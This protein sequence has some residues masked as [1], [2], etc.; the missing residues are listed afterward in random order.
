MSNK[1]DTVLSVKLDATGFKTGAKEVVSATED[2]SKAE[3]KQADA[4][5]K[6][7]DRILKEIRARIAKETRLRDAALRKI[8]ASEKR[9]EAGRNKARLAE[10]RQKTAQIKRETAEIKRNAT[11]K[12]AMQRHEDR[13]ARMQAKGNTVLEKRITLLSRLKRVALTIASLGAVKYMAGAVIGGT[14]AELKG[15]NRQIIMYRNLS[16]GIEEATKATEGYMSK[17]ALLDAASLAQTFQLDMN[18]KSFAV[19][20]RA[21]LKLSK[22]L[23]TDASMAVRDLTVGLARGSRQVLDNLAIIVN[24]EEAYQKYA[25]ANGLVANKLSEVEKRQAKFNEAIEQLKSKSDEGVL[26]LDNIGNAAEKASVQYENLTKSIWKY[27]AAQTATPGGGIGGVMKS[28]ASFMEEKTRLEMY[29]QE[30][31]REGKKGTALGK[32]SAWS[33]GPLAGLAGF[34]AT[35]EV[36]SV[37]EAGQ[38]AR[39][40]VSAEKLLGDSDIISG[41][42]GPIVN[43]LEDTHEDKLKKLEYVSNAIAADTTHY[44][45]WIAELAKGSMTVTEATNFVLKSI[46]TGEMPVKKLPGKYSS[47]GIDEITR[48]SRSGRGRRKVRGIDFGPQYSTLDRD[49]AEFQFKAEQELQKKRIENA[50]Y[51]DKI[52]KDSARERAA[53]V[54][55]AMQEST[56]AIKL[57][58]KRQKEITETGLSEASL[59][60]GGLIGLIMDHRKVKEAFHNLRLESEIAFT[61]AIN[62]AEAFGSVGSAVMGSFAD[63]TI[64]ALVAGEDFTKGFKEGVHEQMKALA[65]MMLMKSLESGAMAVFSLATGNVVAAGK[66]AAASAMLLAGAGLATGVG[67]A[68]YTSAAQ[69]RS[70]GV[71]RGT[72]GTSSYTPGGQGANLT[73]NINSLV[74][75]GD[76]EQFARAI[77]QGVR[78]AKERGY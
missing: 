8:A 61:A 45:K 3:K 14:A 77:G 52:Y 67:A 24:A 49:V 21:A 6:N 73:F 42:L 7:Q 1:K 30:A 46:A 65:S 64:N 60:Q 17:A 9:I 5:S 16:F 62:A 4:S 33:A 48:A 15:A 28:A 58:M 68:T 44:A 34:L 25:D 55:R 56:E 37:T 41:A 70:S 47:K 54:E 26:G 63:A 35:K 75:T 72:G 71:S 31:I 11:A 39:R 78:L 18:A 69:D 43:A 10:I 38:F 76:E 36:Q 74:S 23:G 57:E 20:S 13:L 2:M 66:Y 29:R 32:G 12:L 22:R 50:E 51:L 19:L 27:I 40:R 59:G 53:F